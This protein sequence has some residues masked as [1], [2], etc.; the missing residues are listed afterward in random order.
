MNI[1][2][3]LRTVSLGAIAAAAGLACQP[4]VA[5]DFYAGKNLSIIIGSGAGGGYDRYARTLG[6]HIVKYIPGKPTMVPKN[7]PGAGSAKAAEY[8]FTIAPKDGTTIAHLQPGSL[9]EPL[10]DPAKFRYKPPEFEYLGS[11]NSGTRVCALFHTAKAKTF[12]DIKKIET[13]VGG[14]A[15]GSSTTDY[16]E[17]F[18]NLAGT[19]FKIVNGYK[20][21]S[22]VV[23]AMESGEL[24]GICGF[25]AASF[26]SQRP[27]WYGTKLTNIVVQAG[28]TPDPELEKMGVPS[29]WKYVTGKNREIAELILAQQEFHRPFVAPPGTAAAQLK[30]LREAFDKTMQDKEFL[31]DAAKSK[32][33]IAPKN[34]DTVEKL[35]KKMYAASPDMVAAAKKA[36]GR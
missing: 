8:L 34:G 30:I 24:D 2:Q 14:N 1:R 28:I 18:N 35:I 13:S 36:L 3:S 12:E 16:A 17:M 7:M 32:L 31:A 25:D 22:R 9:V 19:K 10:F 15:P 33:D 23:L 6:R 29:M 27:D 26:K 4:A 5:S 11:A 21:S 20:S